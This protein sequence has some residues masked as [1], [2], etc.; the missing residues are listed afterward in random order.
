MKNLITTLALG[1]ALVT[2]TACGGGDKP[3]DGGT[4]GKT[5]DTSAKTEDAAANTGGS[6]AYAAADHKGSLTGSVKLTGAKPAG[7]ALA[8]AGDEFCT[9]AIA[10]ADVMNEDYV[11]NDDMTIPHAIVYVVGKGPHQDYTYEAPTDRNFHV[12]QKG[13]MYIPH[14]FTVM[15][16]EKFT[17]G[18][19]DATQ[20][21]V[22]TKPGR[23]K[24]F[25]KAQ[26]E[27]EKDTLS[28][29]KKEK[30]FPVVC[31]IHSW[32]AAHCVVTEHPFATVTDATGKFEIKGLPA[33]EYEVK[34][35][36][37]KLG[38]SKTKVTVADAAVSQDL[39][40]AGK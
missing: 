39:E 40:L 15:V 1:F 11:V 16:D 27:G 32:M 28:F 20:H 31:D 10:G 9:G 33:G 4:N 19:E 8:I 35:W 23:A 36:T 30:P 25:N 22:H 5:G 17:I 38:T 14:V 21:N 7:R 24:E 34:V 26:N 12:T 6:K 18:N 3:A 13:C 2:V 37:P 29:S